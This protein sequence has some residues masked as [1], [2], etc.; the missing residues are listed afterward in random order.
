MKRSLTDKLERM[1]MFLAVT[2][3]V[4][5][6]VPVI[7]SAAEPRPSASDPT[8]SYASEKI[9]L[10]RVLEQ[11]AQDMLDGMLGQGKS[12][13]LVN[14]TINPVSTERLTFDPVAQNGDNTGNFTWKDPKTSSPHILPGFSAYADG[15]TAPLAPPPAP[16]KNFSRSFSPYS[17]MVRG[18]N[19]LLQVD[20][21]VSQPRIEEAKTALTPLLGLDARRGDILT[22]Q[23]TRLVNPWQFYFSS[24][25]RIFQF[26]LW[27]L[28]G[29]L[30]LAALATLFAAARY[31][32]NAVTTVSSQ[33]S[34]TRHELAM[35]VLSERRKLAD[36]ADELKAPLLANGNGENGSHKPGAAPTPRTAAAGSQD[37]PV[38]AF[39]SDKNTAFAAEFL[40]KEDPQTVAVVIASINPF[41]AGAILEHFPPDLR[42]DVLHRLGGLVVATPDEKRE[43]A[44]RME[45]FIHSCHDSPGKLSEIFVSASPEIQRHI[46]EGVRKANPVLARSLK[47]SIIHFDNLSELPEEDRLL[48]LSGVPMDTLAAALRGMSDEFIQAMAGPL[49]AGIRAHLD[50]AI[51][52]SK[53]M[54]MPKIK[55]A[56]SA[57]IARLMELRK[58][59]KITASVWAD[60]AEELV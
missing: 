53:P 49:P 41:I 7:T 24:P 22:V 28:L 3:A 9:S 42:S 11:K 58:A 40:K 27:V 26:A 39:L 50:Q 31:I 35:S 18:V 5:S 43:I 47:D 29:L 46:V 20:S 17:N 14:L 6:T 51:R 56:R 55:K 21:S 30:A 15:G 1:A 25:A 19:A 12:K 37:D 45:D 34:S 54:P 52:L 36:M 32:A 59:G 33:L 16:P 23:A 10:E 57:V 44:R 4:L 2:A 13:I 38:F 48:L 8:S 60:A